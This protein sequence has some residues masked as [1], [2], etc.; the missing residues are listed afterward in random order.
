[1]NKL[2]ATGWIIAGVLAAIILLQ[3]QCNS[4]N[5]G[6]TTTYSDTAIVYDSVPIAVS[7]PKSKPKAEIIRIPYALGDSSK[8]IPIIDTQA[9]ITAYY[10]ARYYHDTL[11]NDTNLFASLRYMVFNNK[12][13][14]MQFTY[15]LRR[16]TAII[17]N[18]VVQAKNHRALYLGIGAKAA[19]SI[20]GSASFGPEAY[21]ITQKQTLIGAGYYLPSNELRL[22][23][24]IPLKK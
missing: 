12:T 3:R 16:P 19:V 9:I 10:T 20:G 15:K 17:T 13:D 11:V 6:A 14:S 21:L 1:M 8:R 18:T 2:G 7:L 5:I 24:A 23:I 4:G 22:S